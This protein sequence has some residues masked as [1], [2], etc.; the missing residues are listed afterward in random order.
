MRIYPINFI[1]LMRSSKRRYLFHVGELCVDA[2][3]RAFFFFF[4]TRTISTT[5]EISWD[6]NEALARRN[7]FLISASARPAVVQDKFV[8]REG[9]ENEEDISRGCNTGWMPLLSGMF[10]NFSPT[11]NDEGK[12]RVVGEKAEGKGK[13]ITSADWHALHT[14]TS[15]RI[16]APARARVCRGGEGGRCILFCRGGKG[17]GNALAMSFFSGKPTLSGRVL[18]EIFSNEKRAI[19]TRKSYAILLHTRDAALVR[20]TYAAVLDNSKLSRGVVCRD[21]V[22]VLRACLRSV[23]FR[24]SRNCK[25]FTLELSRWIYSFHRVV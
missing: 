24:N 8:M 22:R 13:I 18:H 17:C 20:Y 9:G 16:C 25:T 23:Q 5:N 14:R 12:K 6:F 3:P 10:R 7:R 11:R 21:T 19:K 15:V 2:V 4:T 1:I